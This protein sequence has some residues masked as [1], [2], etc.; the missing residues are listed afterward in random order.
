M[1]TVYLR[2]GPLQQL[3]PVASTVEILTTGSIGWVDAGEDDRARWERGFRELLD[4]LD[5][6]L[7]VLVEISRDPA[8]GGGAGREIGRASCRERV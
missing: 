5:A 7:Q 6:P 3:L 8:T 2:R 4:G 1:I